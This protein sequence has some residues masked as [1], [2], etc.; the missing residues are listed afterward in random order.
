MQ[1]HMKNHMDSTFAVV[2]R[3]AHSMSLSLEVI[4]NDSLRFKHL[5]LGGTSKNLKEEKVI[6]KR[7]A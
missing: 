4:V 2:Q 3:E 1:L 6:L 7:D 5:V